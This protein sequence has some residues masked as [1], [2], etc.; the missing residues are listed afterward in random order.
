MNKLDSQ[1]MKMKQLNRF[2]VNRPGEK[3]YTRQSLYDIQTYAAAG[4]QQLLFFQVPKGQGGKTINDTNMEAAGQLPNPKMFLV[5]SIEILFFPGV[6]PTTAVASAA[7]AVPPAVPNFANDVYTVAKSG[8]L[9]FF[10]GSKTYLE[11][12]PIGRFPPKTRL[13]SDPAMSLGGGVTG[14]G[15]FVVN[16]AADYASFAGRPYRIEPNILLEPNQNFV[17]ELNWPA[18]VAL[19][20]TTAARIGVVLDGQLIRNSQ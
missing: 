20:S 19:P 5:E 18:V 2:R 14:A 7:I 8:S 17:V 9:K 12:A 10:I 3:E 4:Q 15:D 11:E 13:E 1:A 6:L 16:N